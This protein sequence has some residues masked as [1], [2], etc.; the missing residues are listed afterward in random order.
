MSLLPTRAWL[1]VDLDRL[2]ENYRVLCAHFGDTTAV[3]AVVKANA[4]GQGAVPFARR[5]QQEGARH[6]AVA[7]LGEA[8]ALRQGGI[9]GEILILG[10]TDPRYLSYLLEYRITQA[11][12]STAYAKALSEGATAT[13]KKL[14][15]Q[16]KVDTGM[17]R[18]GFLPEQEAEIAAIYSLPGLSFT[19]IF[20]HFSSA[21]EDTLAGKA[22][23]AEQL[24]KFTHLLNR[25]EERG[26]SLGKRHIAASAGAQRYPEAALDLVRCGALLS[27]YETAEQ[28]PSMGLSPVTALKAEV[29]SVREVPA[30]TPVSYGRTFISEHPMTIATLGIGY[31]DGYP[32]SLSRRGR[33]ILHGAWASQ[34]GNVCMDLMMVD[35]TGIPGVKVGD[36]A[37]ILGQEGTLCQT[38]DE[39]GLA[40]GSCMHELLSRLGERLERVYLEDGKICALEGSFPR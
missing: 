6:F 27:G 4:Y 18:T 34:L 12:G 15:V 25:L 31:A 28:L 5:L 39:L 36:I 9:L 16:T 29:V 23:S 40:A 20:S 3:M 37:T 26:L 32:R 17:A 14:L 22:Y 1:E 10:Y 35:V 13:G 7:T 21:D 30:H 24:W 33:V 19:G 2:A 8:I 38:A 11:V